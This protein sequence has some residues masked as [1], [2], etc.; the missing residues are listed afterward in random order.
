MSYK[1]IANGM[2]MLIICCIVLAVVI[3]Q[4]IVMMKMAGKRVRK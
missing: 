4:P 1:D 3:I 2:P